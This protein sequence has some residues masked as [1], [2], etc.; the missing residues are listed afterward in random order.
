MG[1]I[2]VEVFLRQIEGRKTQR[3]KDNR[4]K[5]TIVWERKGQN[6]RETRGQLEFRIEFLQ[7]GKP[8]KVTGAKPR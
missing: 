1:Q 4:K 7:S 2:L 6:A 5:E 3:I 8:F